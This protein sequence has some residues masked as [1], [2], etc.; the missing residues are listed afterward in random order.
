M[1]FRQN[2][3]NLLARKEKLARLH[4]NVYYR[5]LTTHLNTVTSC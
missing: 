5:L 2:G 3:L 1:K 4:Q